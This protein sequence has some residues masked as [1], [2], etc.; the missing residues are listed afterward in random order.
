MEADIKVGDLVKLVPP[1]M[2]VP[3]KWENQGRQERLYLRYSEALFEVLDLFENVDHELYVSVKN[4]RT[5]AGTNWVIGRVT[6][7]D[8]CIPDFSDIE[9][10]L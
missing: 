5:L 2:Y 6:K 7:S 3:G 8:I 10:L 1:E 9:E 4:T